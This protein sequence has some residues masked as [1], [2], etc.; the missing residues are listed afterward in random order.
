[1]SWNLSPYVSGEK[2]EASL[3]AVLLLE[4]EILVAA[5]DVVAAGEVALREQVVQGNV[6]LLVPDDPD[7]PMV[8]ARLI[9][10]GARAR[11]D[12][13]LGPHDGLDS[14]TLAGLIELHG[15]EHVHLVGQREVSHP[16]GRS[17][18]RIVLWLSEGPQQSELRLH[19]EMGKGAA[20]GVG[21][22][23]SAGH[24]GPG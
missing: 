17:G 16:G 7:E 10:L 13:E 24:E 23:S 18:L 2:D 1:M 9:L 3:D 14:F 8:V 22:R 5:R 20:S 6:A 4:Q 11:R 19:M 12:D 21:H 15:S